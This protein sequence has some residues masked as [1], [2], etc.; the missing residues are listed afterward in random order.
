MKIKVGINGFG[1]IGRQ[2]FKIALGKPEIEVVERCAIEV[3]LIEEIWVV[4]NGAFCRATPKDEM[5]VVVNPLKAV[6]ENAAI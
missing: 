1:R 3:V 6:V 5:L 4:V 2:A